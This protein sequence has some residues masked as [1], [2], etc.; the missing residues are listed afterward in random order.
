MVLLENV[1]VFNCRSERVSAF[2]VPLKRNPL[3]ICGVLVAQGIHILM[4]Q[5][6]FMQKVLGVAPVTLQAWGM[7]LGLATVL[8]VVMELF[9][10]LRR[11]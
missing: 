8:L 2:R 7:L 11:N 5:W 1:H 3:L 4:M 9:K 10:L 6:P